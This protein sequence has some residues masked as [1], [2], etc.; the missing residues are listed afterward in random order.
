[1]SSQEFPFC[2]HTPI[3]AS[4]SLKKVAMEAF[5]KLY[6]EKISDKSVVAPNGDCVLWTSTTSK[7]G[8]YGVLS[9]KHPTE[10]KWKKITVHRLAYMLSINNLNIDPNLDCSHLCHNSLC[11]NVEHLSLESKPINNNRNTCLRRGF[12]QNHE[13]LPPCM[14]HL[15]LYTEMKGNYSTFKAEIFPVLGYFIRMKKTN[16]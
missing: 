6:K 9:Y 13:N 4:V 8:K 12:C 5:F 10:N 7:D 1:M 11:V 16:M 15:K 14:L 3:T 2:I